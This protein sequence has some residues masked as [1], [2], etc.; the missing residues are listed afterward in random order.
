ME[1]IAETA[2]GHTVGAEAS[3]GAGRLELRDAKG[4]DA[5]EADG[6]V[7]AFYLAHAVADLVAEHHVSAEGVE[8]HV[9]THADQ[10]R[11]GEVVQCQVV[12]KD[13]A[14]FDD[15]VRSR[16]LA[17]CADLGLMSEIVIKA[18]RIVLPF[19]KTL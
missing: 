18:K 1:V 13:L 17:R 19:G 10:L 2:G 16:G 6:A 4:I 11:S 14:D 12:L 9:A 8:V 7:V 15:I 5:F 3:A